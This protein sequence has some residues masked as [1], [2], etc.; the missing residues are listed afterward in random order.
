MAN[1]KGKLKA[2]GLLAVGFLT[3]A[4]LVGG[5]V[6]WRYF[7]MF[8]EQYY[9]GI[10][11]NANTALMIRAAQE[12]ELLRNLETNIRQC[13]AAADSLWGNDEDR[14]SAFWLVQRYYERFDLSVPK[15][16]KPILDRLPP[17]PLTSCER[18]QQQEEAEQ[19]Q[20]EQTAPAD[21]Q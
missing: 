18:H 21:P 15:D 14:L 9:T 3:G 17:R 19:Q 12:E 8:K 16:I 6:A 13:V 7:Q 20:A 4:I 5:L 11:S 2:V 10:L 1:R